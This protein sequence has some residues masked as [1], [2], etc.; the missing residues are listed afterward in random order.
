SAMNPWQ[1]YNTTFVPSIEAIQNV[2]VATNSTDAEQGLA[3]GASVNV[4]LKSGSNTVHGAGFAYNIDSAFE[5]QNF[6]APAGTK[7]PHLVDNNDGGN[8]GGH[9]IKDKLFYFGSYEGDY[10]R[11]ANSGLISFPAPTQLGGNFT[12]SANPIY[13]PLTGNANGTGR[14]A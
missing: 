13:D 2:N 4:M 14:T 10:T 5:A 11:Q 7:V 1:A 6:F 9:I 3:G 8:M 12:G